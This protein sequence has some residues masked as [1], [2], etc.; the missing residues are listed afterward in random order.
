MSECILLIFDILFLQISY[1][2]L[3]KGKYVLSILYVLSRKKVTR[4]SG[5]NEKKT[6]FISFEDVNVCPVFKEG[7]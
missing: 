3:S 4:L 5:D 6:A 1:A 2:C 7:L